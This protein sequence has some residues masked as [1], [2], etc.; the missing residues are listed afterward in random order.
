MYS[1]DSYQLTN[2]SHGGSRNLWCPMRIGGQGG[3]FISMKFGKISATVFMA[4]AAVGITTGTAYAAPAA[5]VQPAAVH[6]DATSGVLS[7][8]QYHTVVSP[9]TRAITTTISDGRFV[10][11]PNGSS[12]ALES[13]T[14]QQVDQVSLRPE[15]AGQVFTV[16]QQISPDGRSLTLTPKVSP[17]EIAQA[18]DI[19]AMDNLMFQVNKNI[20]GI[21]G[22]VIIGGLLG[23]LLGLGVLSII[24]APIGAVVGGIGGGYVMGGQ[25]FLNALQAAI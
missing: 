13:N 1:F 4:I 3:K 7:G 10:I 19:T 6:N 11:A 17:Q 14:G 22:G 15:L 21:V 18:K 24:T 25:Q 9:V 2:D 8:I 20:V 12:V 5:P 23:S 16:A